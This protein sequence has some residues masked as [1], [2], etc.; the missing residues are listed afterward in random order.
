MIA[1]KLIAA[2]G[3]RIP[4]V[5]SR[6]LA[7]RNTG[8]VD[9]QTTNGLAGLRLLMFVESANETVPTPSGWTLV[10]TEGVGTPGLIEAGNTASRLTIF[11]RVQSAA[12]EIYTVPDSGDHQLVGIAAFRPCEIEQAVITPISASAS[13]S[14]PTVVTTGKRLIV[15]VVSCGYRFPGGSLD[16][17][18]APAWNQQQTSNVTTQ[19]FFGSQGIIYRMGVM[20]S[21]GTVVGSSWASYQGSPYYN[22]QRV[23]GASATVVLKV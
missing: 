8:P 4:T 9:I 12:G 10:A 13:G 7:A 20:T 2:M 17:G 21:V 6:S 14:T 23:N 22:A 3:G 11:T 16:F 5:H 1:H 18:T 19:L 15:H